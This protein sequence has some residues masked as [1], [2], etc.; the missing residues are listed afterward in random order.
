[1]TPPLAGLRVWIT[2]PQPAAARS[3]EAW[4]KA[5]AVA[6]A[7]PTVVL[8]GAALAEEARHALQEQGREPWTI[9]LTSANAAEYLLAA[10]EEDPALTARVRAWPAHAVGEATAARARALGLR[11]V[12]VSPRATG[13]DLAADLRERGPAR[14]RIL[15]PG[16]DVRR[17]DVETALR[18]AGAEV[19]ACTVYTNEPVS[20]LP[21][22]PARALA[23][24]DVDLIALYSPS[25]L[26]GFLA[27]AARIVDD[28]A[29]RC[30]VAVLGPT[31]REAARTARC[32]VVAEPVA[33]GE[34]A[35]LE[36]AARWWAGHTVE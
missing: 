19:L 7:V 14:G 2:R 3:V 29:G 26:R 36:A 21:A 15:L 30:P 34:A 20:E 6:V 4:R 32:R 22:E 33:P 18:R 17:P 31:T 1:M 24:G 8:A 13:A 12:G 11:V 9:V 28:P 10:L 23:R 5:G 27:A 35:L 25:A 16:S